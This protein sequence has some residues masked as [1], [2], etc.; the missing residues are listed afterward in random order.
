MKSTRIKAI[1]GGANS[2]IPVVTSDEA[3]PHAR[4]GR[5]ICM[6]PSDIIENG[7][8]VIE[9]VARQGQSAAPFDAGSAEQAIDLLRNFA[10]RSPPGKCRVTFCSS[11]LCRNSSGRF[12]AV[13]GR[14]GA[15][16]N[17][18]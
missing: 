9:Q 11:A 3:R 18:L 16:Q 4:L 2:S 8:R 5:S 1:T 15:G 14:W 6:K 13:P 17:K 12:Y 7:H 10:S